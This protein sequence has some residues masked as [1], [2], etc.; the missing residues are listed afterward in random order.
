MLS[1]LSLGDVL[2]N[3]FVVSSSS[4]NGLLPSSDLIFLGDSLSSQSNI[5]DQSLNLGGLLSQWSS[6]VLLALESSSGDILLDQSCG[7]WLIFLSSFNTV[8][9]SDVV[10][11]FGT[12][13]S[14]DGSISDTRDLF[15]SLLNDGYWQIFNVRTDN[16]S[17]YRFSLSFSGSFGSVAS[18]SWS[19][20]E[21]KSGVGEDTLLHGKSVT[22][23]TTGDFENVSLEF[24]SQ[25]IGFNL[26]AHS[27]FEEDSALIIVVDI[28]GFG[29]SVN[30]V[31]DWELE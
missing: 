15:F 7:N 31:R 20:E 4:F 30:R 3:Q 1:G 9:L 10:S 29:C 2:I 25:W 27:F 17:S 26:L 13:S 24:V 19:E 8:E 16:T 22:V 14:W 21:F 23:I 6:G 28:D 12:K 5:S 11:S 18:S